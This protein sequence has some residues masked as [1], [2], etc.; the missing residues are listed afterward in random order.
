MPCPLLDYR[1]C[2]MGRQ[3]CQSK[4]RSVRF[5][6]S[7]RHA[8]L[9][10]RE[11]VLCPGFQELLARMAFVKAEEMDFACNEDRSLTR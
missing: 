2:S 10:E 1:G 8:H 5:L 6:R 11:R 3:A 7:S 9:V 4:L